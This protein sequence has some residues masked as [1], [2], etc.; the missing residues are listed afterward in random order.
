VIEVAKPQL[1]KLWEEGDTFIPKE[2]PKCPEEIAFSPLVGRSYY[3]C[4]PHLWECFWRGGLGEERP[5][6][7]IE[8]FGQTFHVVA[9][10]AFPPPKDLGGEARYSRLTPAHESGLGAGHGYVVELSVREI[11]GQVQAV[12]LTDTCRDTYLPQ[13][14]YGY[15]KAADRKAEGFI[16]DNFDRHIF[17]DRFYVTNQRLNEWFT[18]TGK[19]DRLIRDPKLWPLPALLSREEQHEYC[20]HF[21]K[22]LLEAKLF[23]AATMPPVD[24]RNPKPEFVPR[25]QTP[26]HRDLGK[27]F[28][29]VAR[30]NPDHQ[31]TPLDCQ[32]AQVKGCDEKHFATDSA[33]WMGIFH[34]LGFSPEAFANPIEPDRNLKLSSRLLPAGSEWHELG[35]RSNWSGQ[36]AEL[37]VAFRCYDEVAP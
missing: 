2:G 30:I 24:S 12:M 17:I 34:A 16:W 6:L 18:L 33:S 4:Q 35:V 3:R 20:A 29:G 23:D 9:N 14:I 28:L 1:L 31:L 36:Q 21:G 7:K 11:P 19:P 27:T 15:G 22:R 26:W 32:L 10:A 8:L 5:A 13:R 25:P 37:P